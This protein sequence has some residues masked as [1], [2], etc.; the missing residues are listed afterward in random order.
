[1]RGD[2]GESEVSKE[3]EEPSTTQYGS[4]D[5]LPPAIDETGAG[6]ELTQDSHRADPESKPSLKK[7]KAGKRGRRARKN[8]KPLEMSDDVAMPIADD[9][10]AA[11]G[12]GLNQ[13]SGGACNQSSTM[14]GGAR[15]QLCPLG[16]IARKPTHLSPVTSREVT[17]EKLTLTVDSGASD[18]V[19]PPSCM[20]WSFL[21]HTPKVGS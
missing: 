1:M 11:S 21:F 17:W 18:T 16:G 19:I 8:W 9:K 13:A 6:A 4:S 15:L 20:E 12:L 3:S 7:R 5:G 14:Q 10:S 2:I